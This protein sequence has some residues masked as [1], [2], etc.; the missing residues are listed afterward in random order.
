MTSSTNQT[1]PAPDGQP[2]ILAVV[3]AQPV[4]RTVSGADLPEDNISHLNLAFTMEPSRARCCTHRLPLPAHQQ[5]RRLLPAPPNA[6]SQG[7]R[8]SGSY[9]LAITEFVQ[10]AADCIPQVGDISLG[11][12]ARTCRR[13]SLVLRHRL[14]P[15]HSPLI[16]SMDA[17]VRDEREGGIQPT[18]CS[19]SFVCPLFASRLLM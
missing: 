8:G 17:S 13:D 4:E 9:P 1:N 7:H 5:A 14:S 2:G 19:P 6:P 18:G 15:S 10:T 16:F 11:R 12:C 3:S